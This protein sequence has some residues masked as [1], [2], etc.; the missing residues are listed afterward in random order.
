MDTI[1]GVRGDRISKCL[2][3]ALAMGEDEYNELKRQLNLV[4][5]SQPN[6]E[7]DKAVINSKE[8]SE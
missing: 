6:F 3:L 4:D 7:F 2:E 1:N 5:V 8:V